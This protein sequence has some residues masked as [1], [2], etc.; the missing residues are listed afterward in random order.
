VIAV[1]AMLAVPAGAGT[2][3]ARRTAVSGRADLNR[4]ILAEMNALR[5]RKGLRPLRVSKALK[6]AARVHSTNMARGGFFA[7]ESA[8]GTEFWKRL[9]LFYRS[10]GYR[11]WRVGENLLWASPD[12]GAK[13]ALRLWLKS[14]RHRQILLKPEWRDVGLAAVHAPSAPGAFRGLAVTIVTADFGLRSR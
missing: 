9:E 3:D 8:N 7:H 5:V 12:V 2:D 11:S 4:S 6:L 14:P 10:S 1:V 13:Q